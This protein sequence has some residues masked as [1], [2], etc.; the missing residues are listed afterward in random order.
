MIQDGDKHHEMSGIPKECLRV[1][2]RQVGSSAD[3]QHP[4]MPELPDIF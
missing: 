4:T 3:V 2:I 1:R